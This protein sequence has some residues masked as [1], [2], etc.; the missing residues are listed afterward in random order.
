MINNEY[1]E[2]TQN[3]KVKDLSRKPYQDVD[4]KDFYIRTIK[5]ER[6]IDDVPGLDDEQEFRESMYN[7]G[8]KDDLPTS[9]RMMECQSLNISYQ[10]CFD[11]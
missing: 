11:K 10:D 4:E 8:D 9:D 7:F 6:L 3:V 5:D 1:I 2:Q